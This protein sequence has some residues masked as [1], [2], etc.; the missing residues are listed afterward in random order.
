MLL[1]GLNACPANATD[2]R[3]LDFVIFRTLANIFETF[4][5]DIIN[6]CRTAFSLPLVADI[7][8]TQ[9][10]NFLVRYYASENLVCKVFAQNA[11]CEI[12]ALRVLKL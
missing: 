9:K 7:I 12:N 5:Q 11:E 1:Y 8:R 3:S 4:S 6:E 10:I 2:N